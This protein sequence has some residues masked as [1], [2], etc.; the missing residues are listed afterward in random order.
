[1]QEQYKTRRMRRQREGNLLQAEIN[2][3]VLSA[4][5]SAASLSA[6]VALDRNRKEGMFIV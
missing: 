2:F 4:C 5:I 3:I 1:M 6:E